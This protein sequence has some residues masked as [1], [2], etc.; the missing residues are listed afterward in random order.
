[1]SVKTLT[2]TCPHCNSQNLQSKIMAPNHTHFAKLVCGDCGKYVKW[3]G[4][5]D[6]FK[7]QVSNVPE[8]KSL[9]N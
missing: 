4:K 7:Y 3:L 2:T 9:F 5:S 6:A 8:S 1:M